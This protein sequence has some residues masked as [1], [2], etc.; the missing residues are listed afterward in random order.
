MSASTGWGSTGQNQGFQQN[1]GMNS[2]RSWGMMQNTGFN[3]N[4]YQPQQNSGRSWG[5]MQN[6]QPQFQQQFNSPMGQNQAN[7]YPKYQFYGNPQYDMQM[8]WMSQFNSQG[9][10]SP[11]MQSTMQNMGANSYNTPRPNMSAP[12]PQQN[13]AYQ[14]SL[15]Q[16][17]TGST[18]F[19]SA[20]PAVS[21]PAPNYAANPS[22]LGVD[23]IR[24]RLFASTG[25]S[26]TP[27]A[28]DFYRSQFMTN[29]DGSPYSV[30][31]SGHM[32]EFG[33]YPSM[34]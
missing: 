2:G 5:M 32:G 30:S 25:G 31:T 4:P 20:S 13:Q 24:A 3:S 34:Y 11:V 15:S 29:P 6:T 7:G 9:T 17:I 10:P 8:P 22:P 23:D 27:A 12:A 19:Q 28:T 16:P 26:V 14:Q 21:K 33:K 1:S 18:V